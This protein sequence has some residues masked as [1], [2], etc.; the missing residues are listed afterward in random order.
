MTCLGIGH[1]CLGGCDE[2]PVQ[3][4]ISAG[5]HKSEN[6]KCGITGCVA[7]RGKICIHVVPECAKYRGNHQTTAFKCPAK[8]KV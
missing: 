8:Q 7:K 1:D 4:V 6:H 5:A 3:C 2:R